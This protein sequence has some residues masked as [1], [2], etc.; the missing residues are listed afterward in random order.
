MRLIA[1]EWPLLKVQQ[2]VASQND[3]WQVPAAAVLGLQNLTGRS[4]HITGIGLELTNTFG[5]V[6]ACL[7][8]VL[9]SCGKAPPPFKMSAAPAVRASLWPPDAGRGM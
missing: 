1:V 4:Q 5:M 9:G 8:G 3:E 6:V 7:R 2:S